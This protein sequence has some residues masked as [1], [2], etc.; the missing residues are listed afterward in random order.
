[1]FS[2][3]TSHDRLYFCG[4]VSGYDS[5]LYT[6]TCVSGDLAVGLVLC[7]SLIS[8]L[9]EQKVL[10]VVLKGDTD[11]DGKGF[12]CLVILNYSP[13]FLHFGKLRENE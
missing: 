2:R 9:T 10:V 6:N 3:K 13:L 7:S 12:Y 1:M 8:H 11:L 5:W 4:S